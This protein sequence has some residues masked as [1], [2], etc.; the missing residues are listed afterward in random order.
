MTTLQTASTTFPIYLWGTPLCLYHAPALEQDFF[1]ICQE[2]IRSYD[3]FEEILDFWKKIFVFS[4]E[5]LGAVC[6]KAL[7]HP[8][9]DNNRVKRTCCLV[10]ISTSLCNISLFSGCWNIN[11]CQAGVLPGDDAFFFKSNV[12]ICGCHHHA[13]GDNPHYQR[14]EEAQVLS[15]LRPSCRRWG[16]DRCAVPSRP[17]T[18]I[19]IFVIIIIVII[20]T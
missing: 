7:R 10:M 12:K 6:S 16:W 2:N 13:D 8:L 4:L 18:A 11:D 5:E 3:Y 19:I 9:L 1:T 14:P 17:W 20:L 15:S